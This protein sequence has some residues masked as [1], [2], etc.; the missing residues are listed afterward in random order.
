MA[1]R[2]QCS[3]SATV[4][5]R[6][7]PHEL[8]FSLADVGDGALLGDGIRLT[9][10]GGWIHLLIEREG[11][12]LPMHL[13]LRVSM[14]RDASGRPVVEITTPIENVDLE[15]ARI[16]LIPALQSEFMRRMARDRAAHQRRA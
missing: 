5:L 9:A 14:V 10:E 8:G 12:G 15:R 2:L 13:P 4:T 3:R 16:A 11:C 1:N 7:S 6:I